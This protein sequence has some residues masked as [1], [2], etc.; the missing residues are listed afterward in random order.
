MINRISFSFVFAVVAACSSD[1]STFTSPQPRNPTEPGFP[2][3]NVSIDISGD[4]STGLS[5]YTVFVDGN[6]MTKI[7]P[8]GEANLN[9]GYGQ[10][11]FALEHASIFP[12]LWWCTYR[13]EK[14]Y[15]VVNDAAHSPRVTFRL[16]C[17][18][19]E[20]TGTTS[21]AFY[22]PNI[23][24]KVDV[25]VTLTRLN[26]APFSYLFNAKPEVGNS[27]TVPPGLYRV[28]ASSSACQMPYVTREFDLAR[29]AVRRDI[30][31]SASYTLECH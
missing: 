19:L 16:D 10:H 20:G 18:A 25:S 3:I 1:S 29:V 13:S 12:N 7:T 27:V 8:G 5:E 15:T 11:T 28:S 17:P 9:L 6:S 14:S 26:G 24:S 4:P 2:E 30:N 23:S 31:T 21:L 22:E